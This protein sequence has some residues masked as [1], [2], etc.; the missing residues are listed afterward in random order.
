[1]ADRLVDDCKLAEGHDFIVRDLPQELEI[2]RAWPPSEFENWAVIA[3]GG[4][5]NKKKVGDKGI[6]GRVYPVSVV[7]KKSFM[8]E[9]YPVQAKQKDKAGRPDVDAFEAAMEREDRRLGFLVSFGFSSDAEVEVRAYKRRSG[10]EIVLRTVQ[11]LLDELPPPPKKMAPSIIAHR[12][13]QI[14]RG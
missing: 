14:R 1:M 12:R 7:S 9:W 13:R 2:M 4:I 5:P 8:D 3:V 10:R 11:E 6:D